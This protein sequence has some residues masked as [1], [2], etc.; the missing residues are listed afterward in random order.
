MVWIGKS[1]ISISPSSGDT[2]IIG[3][4]LY[5]E[6]HKEDGDSDYSLSTLLRGTSAYF[7]V[8]VGDRGY[9]FLPPKM[10]NEYILTLKDFCKQNGAIFLHPTNEETDEIMDLDDDDMFYFE[11]L[12]DIQ[13]N[14]DLKRQA[15]LFIVYSISF[16]N[17]PTKKL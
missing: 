13:K 17:G 16:L 2:R 7:V 9:S 4:W 11:D 8:V 1:A 12:K 3:R 14:K 5:D 10:S 15:P 6:T